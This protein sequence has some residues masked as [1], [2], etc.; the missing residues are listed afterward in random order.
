MEDSATSGLQVQLTF[1]RIMVVQCD[2][3]VHAKTSCL[4]PSIHGPLGRRERTR[5]G[6]RWRASLD[7]GIHLTVEASKGSRRPALMIR[8]GLERNTLPFGEA[9]IAGWSGARSLC[10]QDAVDR[11]ATNLEPLGD[12]TRP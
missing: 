5:S 8:C 11:G 10:G 12:L 7:P 1:F 9:L 6:S 2:H 4:A 3:F